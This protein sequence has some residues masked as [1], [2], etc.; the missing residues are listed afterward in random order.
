MH[1]RLNAGNMTD[2][3]AP[4]PPAARWL[5]LAGIAPQA[6]ASM[7][8]LSGDESRWV[9]LAAA[10]GYAALIFSFL[11]GLWW[12][13]GIS[14]AKPRPWIFAVAVA[15]SLIAFATYLPW[16][17]GLDWPQPALMVL[18]LCL[19]SSPLVDQAFA[20]TGIT[21]PAGWIAQR[22]VMSLGLGGLTGVMGVL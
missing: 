11:G 8:V 16:I 14:Q 9:A 19:V 5:G 13:M 20:K 12:G 15:P 2:I 3:I 1:P 4:L 10:Y 22:W 6:L 21:L 18:G 17:W 7:A